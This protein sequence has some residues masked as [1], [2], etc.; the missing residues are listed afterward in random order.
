MNVYGIV[1][2][3]YSPLLAQKTISSWFPPK[4]AGV[5]K[6]H[7]RFKLY[8]YGWKYLQCT[9]WTGDSSLYVWRK[10]SL[11][12]LALPG[13]VSSYSC[14]SWGNTYPITLSVI[15][16]YHASERGHHM[17]LAFV[18][19]QHVP[20]ILSPPFTSSFSARY[21]NVANN[22][23]YR[24]DANY[25][26]ERYT[27][28]NKGQ[29][30]TGRFSR[31]WGCILDDSIVRQELCLVIYSPSEGECIPPRFI[32]FLYLCSFFAFKLHETYPEKIS[33]CV[34]GTKATSCTLVFSSMGKRMGFDY[35]VISL[36]STWWGQKKNY[37]HMLAF[38][39]IVWYRVWLE[40]GATEVNKLNK[41]IS[42]RSFD[43]SKRI[44]SLYS[45]HEFLRIRVN[46]EWPTLVLR[47]RIWH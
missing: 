12:P 46:N 23:E 27:R 41:H 15:Q 17:Y 18:A 14:Q 22:I 35:S 39:L 1:G 30:L 4:Y 7:T 40:V 42:Q 28:A 9:Y 6:L 38:L 34:S 5:L 37:T 26:L 21:G 43:P 29:L 33:L 10:E 2:E 25:L 44:E 32:S 8:F 24:N 11:G 47:I 20:F 16:K 13:S 45:Q 31:R 3:I 36:I 19:N